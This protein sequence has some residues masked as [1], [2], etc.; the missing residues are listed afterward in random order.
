MRPDASGRD[1]AGA[2]TVLVLAMAGLLCFVAV[3]LAS[4]AGMVRA[5]RS[6]QSAADLAALA[7]A[8]ALADGQ[9]GCAAAGSVATAN[10]AALAA[11]DVRGRD[12]KVTVV[13]RSPRW[14]GR[15]ADVTAEARAGPA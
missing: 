2:A 15:Q 14:A 13:V 3:A 10:G 7:A 12:A 1:E 5:Q 9:D 4:V 8:G 6:A 11:C